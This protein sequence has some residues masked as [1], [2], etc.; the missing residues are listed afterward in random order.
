MASPVK[1]EKR[2]FRVGVRQDLG[3]I[4]DILRTIGVVTAL[5]QM[6]YLWRITRRSRGL[7][8]ARGL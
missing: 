5:R 2:G 8:L 7:A 3:M 6:A 4:A 1:A